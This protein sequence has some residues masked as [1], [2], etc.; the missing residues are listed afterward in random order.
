MEKAVNTCPK[1]TGTLLI[2]GGKEGKDGEDPKHHDKP[3]DYDPMAILKAFAGLIKDKEAAV[4]VVTTGSTLGKETFAEYKKNFHELGLRKINHVHHRTRK[5]LLEDDLSARL[6]KCAAVF[7]AGGDQLTLTA[8]YGGSPFLSIVKERYI[9]DKLII[10]G[11]SAGAMALST[12]MIYAGRKEIEQLGG[13]IKV[14]TGLEFLK[15]VCVDT[16]FVHRGRFVR[17]AQVLASNPTC[18]GMGIDEDTA[19]IIRNGTEAE[20]LGS[21]VIIVIEAFQMAYSNIDEAGNKQ[22]ISI[23]DL[24]VHLLGRGDKYEIPQMNPP[25]Q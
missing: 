15:D 14:T 7:F 21:G 12:P 5:E 16:H 10:A 11:T 3:D 19:M 20:V 17:M 23:R 9:Y 2:I 4:E 18:I 6:K 24:K 8:I 13:E 1:P 25:H 22:P